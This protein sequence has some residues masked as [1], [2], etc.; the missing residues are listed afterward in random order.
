MLRCVIDHRYLSGPWASLKLYF[1]EEK[2][3]QHPVA[4][5]IIATVLSF[6]LLSTSV[7]AAPAPQAKPGRAVSYKDVC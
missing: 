5:K 3:I 7:Y 6:T 1:G 2:M 4:R